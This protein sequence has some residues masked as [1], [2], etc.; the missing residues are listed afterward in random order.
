MLNKGNLVEKELDKEWVE[1]MEK[2]YDM[3]L[4]VQQ[5]KEF[6]KKNKK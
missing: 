5:V 4:S 2:A 1:L 3:G 6:L